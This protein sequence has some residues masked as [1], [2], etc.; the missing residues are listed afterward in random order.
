M[1][2]NQ[3]CKRLQARDNTGSVLQECTRLSNQLAWSLSQILNKQPQKKRA[4]SCY[5]MLFHVISRCQASSPTLFL[6]LLVVVGLLAL[7][8]VLVLVAVVVGML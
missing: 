1:L 2:R 3:D 5:F 7:V 6:P 4:M 8:P